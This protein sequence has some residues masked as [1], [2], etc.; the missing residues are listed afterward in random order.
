MRLCSEEGQSEACGRNMPIQ[1]L[2]QVGA[3]GGLSG[4]RMHEA[5]GQSGLPSR[6]MHETGGE[7]MPGWLHEALLRR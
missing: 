7:G 4:K 1:W 3:K 2:Q 5:G 6:R